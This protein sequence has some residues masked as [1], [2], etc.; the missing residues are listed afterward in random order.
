MPSGG[1]QV[2]YLIDQPVSGV[3][4]RFPV[5]ARITPTGGLISQEYSPNRMNV[6]L[7]GAGE[8]TRIWCG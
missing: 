2:Q 3:R 8:I 5:G 7:D 6:D 1:D 4:D